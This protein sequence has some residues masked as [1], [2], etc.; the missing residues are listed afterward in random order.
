MYTRAEGSS[1]DT[2]CSGAAE[3]AATTKSL[4]SFVVTSSNDAAFT[5]TTTP[6]KTG[7]TIALNPD[8]QEFRVTPAFAGTLFSMPSAAAPVPPPQRWFQPAMDFSTRPTTGN[9]GN[10]QSSSSPPPVSP[11]ASAASDAMDNRQLVELTEAYV[12]QL[13]DRK[14]NDEKLHMVS[15]FHLHPRTTDKQLSRIFF[16]TGASAAEVLEPRTMPEPLA[17]AFLAVRQRAG[18]VFFTCKDFAMVGVEKVHDFVPHGQHQPLVVRYCGPDHEATPLSGSPLPPRSQSSELV[19]GDAPASA[20]VTSPR[21]SGRPTPPQSRHRDVSNPSDVFPASVVAAPPLSAGLES[22]ASAG[23]TTPALE[24]GTNST[25][26]YDSIDHHFLQKYAGEQVYLVGVHNLA[27]GTTPK[28]L[29]KMFYPMGALN[30]ELVPRPVSVDGKLRC[31]GVAVFGSKGM[32][33]EAAEKMNDFVPHGQ[34]RPIVARFLKGATSPAFASSAAPGNDSSTTSSAY[35]AT[36]ATPRGSTSSPSPTSGLSSAAA[37]LESVE[38]QLRSKSLNDS[39][40]AADMAALVLCAESGE[41]EARKL[42]AVLRDVLLS[43]RDHSTILAS[44]LSGAFRTLHSTLGIRVRTA[45]ATPADASLGVRKGILFLQQ[46]GRTLMMLVADTEAARQTRIVAAVQCAYFYQYTYLP[47]TPLCFATTLFRNCERELRE[48]REFLCREPNVPSSLAEEQQHRPWIT[49]MDA[50]HEMVSVWR[51]LDPR[52]YAQD[53]VREEYERFVCEFRGMD[54]KGSSPVTSTLSA[55]AIAV[56]AAAAGGGEH[57]SGACTPRNDALEVPAEAA[58][59]TYSAKGHGSNSVNASAKK[60]QFVTPSARPTPRR[61]VSKSYSTTSDWTVKQSTPLAGPNCAVPPQVMLTSPASDYTQGASEFS[62]DSNSAGTTIS[63]LRS[64][65]LTPQ[66]PSMRFNWGSRL[67]S[68][69]QQPSMSPNPTVS[70]AAMLPAKPTLSAPAST[71]ATASASSGGPTATATSA[72][73]SDA[74]MTERTVYITKLPSCLSAGQVRRLLRHFGDFRKVRLCHD[75]KETTRIGSAEALAAHSLKFDQ[76]CFGFVEFVESCSAKAMV[77]FFRNEVHTPKAF[78]FLRS[79]DVHG[80]DETGFNQLHNTRTSQARN[81]IHDQ[82]PL[83]ATRT[84]PCLFGIIQ[85]HHTVDTYSDAITAEEVA[86]AVR[87]LHRGEEEGAQQQQQLPMCASSFIHPTVFSTSTPY[88]MAVSKDVSFGSPVA[89]TTSPTG[90]N[91][92]DENDGC[93]TVVA[94]LQPMDAVH[95]PR[96]F[97]YHEVFAAAASQTGDDDGAGHRD[98]AADSSDH[99]PSADM[100]LYGSGAPVIVE[101]EE[102]EVE[103]LQEYQVQQIL[104]LLS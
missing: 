13:Y 72:E 24:V 67:L 100:D 94:A 87:Q 99:L 29:F 47:K 51:S 91:T 84:Q 42:A 28:S 85:P 26:A 36:A 31:S 10:S 76:L 50:L 66:H 17:K 79:E 25:A 68:A 46:I 27:Y 71:S 45:P 22:I 101:E 18:V 80:F 104:Q 16:P 1:H 15:V 81:P 75:D 56:A 64:L 14:C 70:A 83:D 92:Y 58:N 74:T 38:K 4:P 103:G 23:T 19:R 97:P 11:S 65:G 39:Q 40:L 53:T 77:E 21:P 57:H 44:P 86:E 90:E 62:A 52:T 69:T 12:H 6:A 9:N 78:D 63:A 33:V 5:K 43:M 2:P 49:L 8:A 55:A 98:N 48:A 32:A 34:R 20:K 3:T 93:T 82:Q 102:D 59:K 61:V 41:A 35:T 73:R 95:F 30:S 96:G 60:S 88:S 37:L 54:M 7:S 89:A